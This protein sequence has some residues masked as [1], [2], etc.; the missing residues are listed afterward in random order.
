M[1]ARNPT[2]PDP[3]FLPNSK[4]RRDCRLNRA[5]LL[6]GIVVV[7]AYSGFTLWAN[8]SGNY[9]SSTPAWI[10]VSATGSFGFT[11]L[12]V[13]AVFTGVNF[14]LLRKSDPLTLSLANTRRGYR[15]SLVLLVASPT[16]IVSLYALVEWF[17]STSNQS[18]IVASILLLLFVGGVGSIVVAVVAVFIAINW[19]RSRKTRSPA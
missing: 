7:V 14:S 6:T 16:L 10:A 9:P 13:G 5:T 17:G 18:A 4:S 2:A 1:D 12:T 15:L 8:A 19:S 3:I 11:L